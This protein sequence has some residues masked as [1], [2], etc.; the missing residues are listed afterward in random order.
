MATRLRKGAAAAAGCLLFASA[1]L[2][3]SPFI[4]N[5]IKYKD[6]GSRPATG[7][8]GSASLEARALIGNDNRTVVEVTANGTLEKVQVR[9]T[10]DVTRNFNNLSSGASFS[11]S[12]DDLAHGEPVQ[13][14]AN[15]T[16]ADP[17]RTD[18]VTVSTSVA[19]R[20]DLAVASL[21]APPHGYVGGPMRI[22]A[23]VRELNGETG[24]RASCVLSVNGMDVDRA[25]DIWVDAGGTVSC[26]FAPDFESAGD[27]EFAVRVENVRPGDGDASND[28]RSGSLKIY[29]EAEA[30]AY[31]TG[32]AEEGTFERRYRTDSSWYTN[33]G[34]Q[35][36]WMAN[37]VFTASVP[38]M[39]VDFENLHVSGWESTDGELIRESLDTPLGYYV[40]PG[41]GDDEPDTQCAMA[42][43]N[44]YHWFEMCENPARGRFPG[45]FWIEMY[46]GAG[47]VT[48]RSAGWDK[49]WQISEPPGYYTWNQNYRDV[50]G[51]Q[52]PFGSQVEF[53]M[54]ISD[55]TSLWE[56]NGIVPLTRQVSEYTQ[57]RSCYQ[58]WMGESCSEYYNRTEMNAGSA[59][60][61]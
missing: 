17:N 45:A 30:F 40:R 34:S 18:V 3:D 7:R 27:K 38:G 52:K 31:W 11:A 47:D 8:S 14:Q 58:T 26:T 2:A 16:G 37:T 44:P 21:S 57:P 23:T 56:A 1:A 29:D 9:L 19:R 48:Y 25:D 28:S 5:S 12:F 42:F 33:E 35:V 10:S 36:G 59:W 6:S 15:V 51:V 13:V 61:N 22:H 32:R 24:A 46:R 39:G 53:R 43:D 60:G 55:G 20:P 49:T 50:F 54:S 4:A 41:W